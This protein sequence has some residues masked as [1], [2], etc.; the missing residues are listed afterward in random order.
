MA[1]FGL[2]KNMHFDWNGAGF[3][4]Y[5]LQ[6]NGDVLLEGIADGCISIV[7]REQLLDEYRAGN[8][9]AREPVVD[10]GYT[11]QK[12]F[13]RPLDELSKE[14]QQE[15]V[16]RRHYLQA[17][18]NQGR[19]IF[20]KEY[21][22]P[23]ILRAA[24]EIGDE[25]PPGVTSV[26]RW[27]R[28]YQRSEDTRALIPRFDR[29]GSRKLK[30]D[31]RLLQL[32][33]EAIEE[34]F[35]ASP[36]ATGKSIYTRLVGKVTTANTR[37]LPSE[38]MKQP[39]LRTFH[40]M[41]N[42][43]DSYDFAVLKEGKVAADKRYRVLMTGL[44]TTQILERVEMDH[45]PLDLFIIDEKTWLPLGRPTLTVV[46]DHFSRML[47]GYH[48]S[49]DNPSTAAVMG[50]LR[51]AILP[52]TPAKEA[53]PNVKVE[54]RWVCYGQPDLIV[55]DNGLEF[56]G[57]DLDSVVFDLKSKIQFC[58]KYQPR[59]KG[60]VERFLGTLNYTFAHQLPGTSFARF[61]QRGDYD[62][63]RQALLTLAEFNHLFEKW[64][65]D[66]YAQ[67]VHRG[68]GT[69]PWAKWHEGIKFREPELPE[70]IHALKCRIGRVC[71]RSLR[72]DGITIKGLRYNGDSLAEILRF[73]GAGVLVRVV[74][75]PEDLGE[76]QVWGPD[77]QLPVVVRALDYE[78]AN[79][80]TYKQNALIRESMREKGRSHE[81]P[82]SL[83]SARYQITQAVD[84]LLASRKQRD[85][86]RSAALRGLSS[87]KPDDSLQSAKVLENKTPKLKSPKT[88][89]NEQKPATMPRLLTS[90]QMKRKEVK[91]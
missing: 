12:V 6:P 44:P 16:R 20:T 37:M 88:P 36:Q 29:R 43:M 61:Y 40:R 5:R 55:V 64:V 86:R 74:Y 65:V 69:T 50:A 49:F 63:Q 66:V 45:T 76:I 23:L 84:E 77:D 53:L 70:S 62:P 68:I 73:H 22:S 13:S 25:K 51:H 80:M 8:I 17:I 33:S 28:K 48:L 52:K 15:V 9:S 87:S 1:G 79:G 30:Q 10:A 7:K 41:L 83:E 14:V 54:H 35:K 34:A 59:Y 19:P 3:M 39:T 24:T 4:I 85:R 81:H 91:S 78:Y 56:H 11:S 18:F 75:D 67:T 21:L 58:P 26:Y 38:Q 57:N 46:M 31:E 89:R 47:L 90:F 32:A 60:V 27:C 2:R 42:R 72:Q 82:P 71:E